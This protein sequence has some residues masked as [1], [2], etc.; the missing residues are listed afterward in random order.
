MFETTFLQLPN[1]GWI[2]PVQRNVDPDL[3]CLF[4]FKDVESDRNVMQPIRKAIISATEL[5]QRI[6]KLGTKGQSCP[7]A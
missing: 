5:V 1:F 7:C 3:K 6:R 4:I 2:V